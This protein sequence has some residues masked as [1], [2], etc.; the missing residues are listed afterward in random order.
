MPVA[1][2]HYRG[3]SQAEKVRAKA[4]PDPNLLGYKDNPT[5]RRIFT[6]GEGICPAA[7]VDSNFA[8]GGAGLGTPTASAEVA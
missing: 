6:E 2:N 1:A 8:A 7:E 5:L 4:A 3:W